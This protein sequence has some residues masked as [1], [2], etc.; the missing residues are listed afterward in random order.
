MIGKLHLRTHGHRA[1]GALGN[2]VGP[3][4]LLVQKASNVRVILR[5]RIRQCR[6]TCVVCS[7]KHDWGSFKFMRVKVGHDS[8]PSR[9]DIDL[10]SAQVLRSTERQ[11]SAMAA[12]CAPQAV[13][14]RRVLDATIGPSATAAN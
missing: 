14:R 4:K 11:L 2:D 3:R 6:E 7:G 8:I 12:E 1:S 10:H 9:L 13:K 5:C